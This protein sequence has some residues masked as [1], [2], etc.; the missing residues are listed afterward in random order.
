MSRHRILFQLCL[1]LCGAVIFWSCNKRVENAPD[2]SAAGRP[3]RVQS[4]KSVQPPSPDEHRADVSQTRGK[5]P[6]RPVWLDAAAKKAVIEGPRIQVLMEDGAIS[7]TAASMLDLT[8]ADAS[9]LAEK[10]KSLLDAIG[11]AEAAR[12]SEL[13]P[14]KGKIRFS[15]APGPDAMESLTHAAFVPIA[16]RLGTERS[17][18]L[19]QL[20][21][22]MC[23][24]EFSYFG[25]LRT[26]V[27]FSRQGARTTVRE[28]AF[29]GDVCVVLKSNSYEQ[30][31]PRF[32]RIFAVE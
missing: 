14:E 4:K 2:S 20:I 26:V 27:S 19:E 16:E 17:A 18:F 31:P 25:E 13:P 30:L 12:V 11:E 21:R 28:E 32:E 24:S 6:Q 1:G 9:W 22:T 10:F 8:S 7:A 15:I 23:R 3:S 29:D 5:T